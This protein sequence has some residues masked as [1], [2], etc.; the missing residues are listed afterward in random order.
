[1]TY[2]SNLDDQARAELLCYL[3]VGQLVA[4]A[5][6]SGWMRTVHVEELLSIWLNG[7]GARADWMD[8]VH[9]RALSEKVALGF[10]G[11]PMFAD[12]YFLAQLFTDGWRLDYRSPVVCKIYAACE[13]ELQPS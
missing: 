3:V 8:C 1:M 12:S 5:R 9:L 13:D 7:N 4:R 6:T 11:F 2:L 10:A